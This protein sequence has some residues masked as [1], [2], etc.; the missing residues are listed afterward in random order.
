MPGQAQRPGLGSIR[1]PRANGH[2]GLYALPV[3]RRD[4]IHQVITGDFA[5]LYR[6]ERP[7]MPLLEATK[8][9]KGEKSRH[10]SPEPGGVD[11]VSR[12]TRSGRR[13][14]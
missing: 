3:N 9:E 8:T 10:D 12:E 14:R 6:A 11:S 7:V 4:S 1:N 13:M 2:T 5:Y